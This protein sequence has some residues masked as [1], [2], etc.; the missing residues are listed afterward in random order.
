MTAI[1][2]P[3]AVLSDY[4]KPGDVVCS[5]RKSF[6]RHRTRWDYLVKNGKCFRCTDGELI[7]MA[8]T[9]KALEK[10]GCKVKWLTSTD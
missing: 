7:G 2:N 4:V 8:A 6:W 9:A 10:K 1:R 3:H 5:E